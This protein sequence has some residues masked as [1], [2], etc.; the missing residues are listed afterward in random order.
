MAQAYAIRFERYV[1]PEPNS[2]CWLWTG[3]YINSGY[4]VF[5]TGTQRDRDRRNTLAHR[6]ALELSGVDV[7]ETAFVLHHC[8]NK[9]C[10][11]PGHLYV[12][13][14]LDNARDAVERGRTGG[15]PFP[16]A[17][18]PRAKLSE[19]DAVAIIK[20]GATVTALARQ[21]GVSKTQIS[22]IKQG[23]SWRHLHGAG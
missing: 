22:Y 23:K 6:M 20:S 4:G 21:Y 8:D 10:V 17:S 5:R 12:G 15:K 16:G 18:N 7:P 19:S 13:T 14:R 1:S 9:A 11:N 3:A 2:G